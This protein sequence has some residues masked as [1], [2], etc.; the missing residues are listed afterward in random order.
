MARRKGRTGE[1]ELADFI[2][3]VESSAKGIL[4]QHMER[5]KMENSRTRQAHR[6]R[7]RP[8]SRD[9]E[10]QTM[11]STGGGGSGS[12]SGAGMGSFSQK[13][14]HSSSQ[15]SLMNGSSMMSSGLM[16]PMGKSMTQTG[17]MAPPETPGGYASGPMGEDPSMSFGGFGVSP[18]GGSQTPGMMPGGQTPGMFGDSMLN[19]SMSGTMMRGT[20][21]MGMSTMQQSPALGARSMSDRTPPLPQLSQSH[22]SLPKAIA[23]TSKQQDRRNRMGH[24]SGMSRSMSAG[25]NKSDMSVSLPQLQAKSK[26]AIRAVLEASPLARTRHGQGGGGGGGRKVRS[27]GGG[28]RHGGGGGGDSNLQATR[29]REAWATEDGGGGGGDGLAHAHS[30]GPPSVHR[31]EHAVERRLCQACW[32]KPSAMTGNE[33][34]MRHMEHALLHD[35]ELQGPTSWSSD[36]LQK[37]Y[38][39]EILREASWRQCME[40][41]EDAERLEREENVIVAVAMVDRHPM[42]VHLYRRIGEENTRATQQSRMQN[43]L[44]TFSLDMKT[45]WH[46][47]R[48]PDE[49]RIHDDG[50]E[51]ASD[52]GGLP[53]RRPVEAVHAENAQVQSVSNVRATDGNFRSSEMEDH[54]GPAAERIKRAWEDEAQ[55]AQRD[56][57]HKARTERRHKIW[58]RPWVRVA[59]V[60]PRRLEEFEEGGPTNDT[61]VLAMVASEFTRATQFTLRPP[62][63]PRHKETCSRVV[64]SIYRRGRKHELHWVFNAYDPLSQEESEVMVNDEEYMYLLEQ[65]EVREDKYR[66]E[67]L[68]ANWEEQ[69]RLAKEAEGAEAMKFVGE[70]ELASMV[71][72]ETRQVEQMHFDF[73]T[74]AQET[75]AFRGV[76]PMPCLDAETGAPTRRPFLVRITV[77]VSQHAPMLSAGC[78]QVSMTDPVTEEQCRTSFLTQRVA[79]LLTPE[80]IEHDALWTALKSTVPIVGANSTLRDRLRAAETMRSWWCEP[81]RGAIWERVL[82][83][84]VCH[85]GRLLDP[86]GDSV[87]RAGHL[88]SNAPTGDDTDMVDALD[89]YPA[90][91]EMPEVAPRFRGAGEA[92][93]GGAGG[94]GGG[95]AGKSVWDDLV[96]EHD[97]DGEGEALMDA[98]EAAENERLRLEAEAAALA[99]EDEEEEEVLDEAEARKVLEEQIRRTCAVLEMVEDDATGQLILSIGG[100]VGQVGL[101]G[102][103]DGERDAQEEAEEAEFRESEISKRDVFIQELAEAQLSFEVCGRT[104]KYRQVPGTAIFGE[105]EVATA[106]FVRDEMLST[107]NSVL[108]TLQTTMQT[109]LLA[110]LAGGYDVVPIQPPPCGERKDGLLSLWCLEAAPQDPEVRRDNTIPWTT[111]YSGDLPAVDSNLDERMPETVVN[112]GGSAEQGDYHPVDEILK[113]TGHRRTVEAVTPQGFRV[114]VQMARDML[115]VPTHLVD[116]CAVGVT[117]RAATPNT[118][119]CWP[120]THTWHSDAAVR[121]VFSRTRHAADYAYITGMVQ[122]I[123]SNDPNIYLIK[124]EHMRVKEL[125]S[126]RRMDYLRV[127]AA[128]REAGAL[129]QQE[130]ALQQRIDDGKKAMRKRLMDRM[131]LERQRRE[132]ERKKVGRF[133][134]K[135]RGQGTTAAE[136]D[137]RIARSSGVGKWKDWVA[138]LL[139]PTKAEQAARDPGGAVAGGPDEGTIFYHNVQKARA[140]P[141]K[142]GS[143]WDQPVG[144][145]GPITVSE[146]LLTK[147]LLKQEAGDD[148]GAL[149][150]IM[151]KDGE[152]RVETQ[153]ER[154]T[155]LLE[156]RRL[157]KERKA[158]ERAEFKAKERETHLKESRQRLRQWIRDR[159]VQPDGRFDFRAPFDDFDTSGDGYVDRSEFAR[160][161][162]VIFAGSDMYLSKP[163]MTTLIDEFDSNQDGEISF[164]EFVKWS[165][166]ENPPEEVVGD[167]PLPGKHD[168]AMEE[169]EAAKPI[170]REDCIATV[171]RWDELVDDTTDKKYYKNLDT[172]EVSWE[173]PMEL[174]H[175]ITALETEMAF[176]TVKARERSVRSELNETKKRIHRRTQRNEKE[177]SVGGN[178]EMVMAQLADNPTFLNMLANRLAGGD[179]SVQGGSE[180]GSFLSGVDVGSAS[181]RR[182]GTAGGEGWSDEPSESNDSDLISATEDE[183]SGA[184]RGGDG[185][186]DDDSTY[187]LETKRA[188]G[189]HSQQ[190][191]QFGLTGT[192][193]KDEQSRRGHK[194]HR[195]RKKTPNHD[196]AKRRHGREGKERRRKKVQ[197]AEEGGRGGA[198]GSEE[199]SEEDWEDTSTDDEI[200]QIREEEAHE[201][202]ISGVSAPR[203]RGLKSTLQ[204]A[205]LKVGERDLHVGKAASTHESRHRKHGLVLKNHEHGQVVGEAGDYDR[206]GLG[207]RRLK[208]G[209]IPR[210]FVTRSTTPRTVGPPPELLS[211]NEASMVGVVDPVGN[212]SHTIRIREHRIQTD[213]IHDVLKDSERLGAQAGG[214]AGGAGGEAKDEETKKAE[215]LIE[216]KHK[217]LLAVRGDDYETIDSLLDEGVGADTMDENGNTLFLVSAQQGL[218][219]ICKLLLRRGA[220]MNNVNNSGNTALHYCFAYSFSDLGEY[221]IKKGADDS[222]KNADGLTCYEGLNAANMEDATG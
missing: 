79:E 22:G 107:T 186:S 57:R 163:E 13:M 116:P 126:R 117:E 193:R 110:P 177:A 122:D 12:G 130:M 6:K 68:A 167:Q 16:T 65:Q 128:Q 96:N 221:L 149:A 111:S 49:G 58:L 172:G 191:V 175:A 183:E 155:R 59:A 160:L 190:M 154:D 27:A 187:G 72:E 4:K 60:I 133:K 14:G 125:A 181:G 32:Q 37:K 214:G 1:D 176:E 102:Q 46:V 88:G 17:A 100:R 103:E 55:Q 174:T 143:Q 139:P 5:R 173:T 91:S 158:K 145:D 115:T 140:A 64:M 9:T 87:P 171:A 194:H 180:T 124:L 34:G 83:R 164:G 166:W 77:A 18:V 19:S 156:Q 150:V 131:E 123:G 218:K 141:N 197:A 208:P 33:A 136:W 189:S 93:G 195:S 38:R 146:E 3:D 206:P 31:A 205:P 29:L 7:P 71:L 101:G 21:G 70:R 182:P 185:K 26:A 196:S 202:M 48:H 162:G 203:A 200:R 157:R 147:A 199:G 20:P 109:A 24:A 148:D 2:Y 170:K 97:G 144:W 215:L 151:D 84:V 11:N 81:R 53:G 210:H 159:G 219:R 120:R 74:Q 35:Q 76:V 184:G 207:W 165:M 169:H 62:G 209:Q 127:E 192:E 86:H 112:L 30:H 92:G 95:E 168:K 36:D 80:E 142:V 28:G 90:T 94:S 67:Q 25:R 73:A 8:G 40:K 119:A 134:G 129:E 23:L 179:G 153:E 212:V 213:M 211:G 108:V 216:N 15:G 178:M 43:N 188:D 75:T 106:V 220:N 56:A 61:D 85:H 42:Y 39:D 78:V 44:R 50:G 52:A 105:A 201:D 89:F 152:T 113:Y 135:G 51:Y 138:F 41:M 132:A 45:I 47:N 82:E 69:E 121:G 217:A 63:A 54:M 222:I 10:N 137:E 204:H 114:L 118:R 98:A 161:L 99:G 66:A 104:D 198:E